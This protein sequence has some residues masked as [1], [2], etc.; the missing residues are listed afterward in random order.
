[1]IF[2]RQQRKVTNL[3]QFTFMRISGDQPI[4][5]SSHMIGYDSCHQIRWKGIT[6]TIANLN[7][8]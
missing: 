4:L 8:A 1:M 7:L 3:G 2:I 6:L 5:G